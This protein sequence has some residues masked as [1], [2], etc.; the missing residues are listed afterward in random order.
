MIL[1]NYKVEVINRE[2][3]TS[4]DTHLFGV[5]RFGLYTGAQC[6]VVSISVV[7]HSKTH[8]KEHG[9][10]GS[11]H[12][13]RHAKFE[14]R[15]LFCCL[16]GFRIS[17]FG[18]IYCFASKMTGAPPLPSTITFAFC[19]R[20]ISLYAFICSYCNCLSVRLSLMMR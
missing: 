7:I 20:A 17:I 2:G 4:A 19:D 15:K 16:F 18:F 9:S 6:S 14:F 13:I 10:K 1:A 12:K 5:V 8:R 11:A 3:V